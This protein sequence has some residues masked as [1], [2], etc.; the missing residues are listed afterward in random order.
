M[1]SRA[2]RH[3]GREAVRSLR[4]LLALVAWTCCSSMLPGIGVG[5]PTMTQDGRDAARARDNRLCNPRSD[6]VGRGPAASG[7][8]SLRVRAPQEEKAPPPPQRQG[9]APMR[10]D[11]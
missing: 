11:G 5:S 6:L 3:K 4:W 8:F 7:R 9:R 10:A 2:T 1:R